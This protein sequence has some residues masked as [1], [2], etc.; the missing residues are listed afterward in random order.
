MIQN[1]RYFGPLR[2]GQIS[3]DLG[4]FV[5]R[6]IIHDDMDVEV[7]GN[8]PVDLLKEVEELGCPVPLV[9]LADDEA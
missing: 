1:N 5:G 9:A 3:L 7:V 6:V 8:R 4:G 2:R